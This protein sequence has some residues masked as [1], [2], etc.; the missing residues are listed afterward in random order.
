MGLTGAVFA[1][2]T[3]PFQASLVPTVAIYERTQRIEGVALSIWGENPQKGF[4]LG[5]V[6]GST[7]DST[8]LSW[9]FFGNYADKYYGVQLGMVNIAKEEFTGLQWGFGNYA[10]DLSG[11]QLGFLN[12]AEKTDKGVQ[13]GFINILPE[14]QKWFANLPDEVAPGMIFVNWNF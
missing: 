14:N 4:A 12:Y 6:N 11:L 10:K 1:E 13:V 3:K 7:G 8:G 2:D 5:F 9:G